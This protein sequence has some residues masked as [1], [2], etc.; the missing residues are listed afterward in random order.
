[1]SIEAFPKVAVVGQR[2]Q[3]MIAVLAQVG[4]HAALQQRAAAGRHC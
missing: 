4:W 1:M 3:L 2:L